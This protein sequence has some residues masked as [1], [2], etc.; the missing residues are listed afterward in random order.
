M[1]T[2]E[3]VYLTADEEDKLHHRPG[4]R[5]AGRRGE[6]SR[7]PASPCAATSAFSSRQSRPRRLHGRL[8]QADRGRLG[9]ADPVPGARRRQPRPD[10]LEHAAQAVPL[11][12]PEAPWWARA[13]S[14]QSALDSGQVVAGQARRRGHQRDRR[15]DRGASEDGHDADYQAA[16]VQPLQPEH[17]HRPA[18]GGDKGDSVEQGDVL[19][20]SAPPTWASWRWGRTCWWPSCPGK[21]ATTRMP[22]SS[23]RAG[24]R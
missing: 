24:A 2:D 13:W 11:L 10:G 16:Q 17:L 15:H 8:A 4:Q 3:I 21:A 12:Q 1:A 9:G 19:A 23:A 6:T 7:Q 22:S 14:G 18:A 20:D 5:R